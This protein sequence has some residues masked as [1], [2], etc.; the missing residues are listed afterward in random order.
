MPWDKKHKRYRNIFSKFT[1]YAPLTLPTIAGLIPKDLNIEIEACD[2]MIE[3]A[4]KYLKN[5]Y[6]IVMFSF[7]TPSS[8]RAYYLSQ[9]F[10]ERGAYTVFG[11]YHTTFIPE[12]AR[13][14]ADTIII[15]EGEISIPMFINDY[16]KGDPKDSYYNPN[17]MQEH[18]KTPDRSIL[19]KHKYSKVPT[20]IASKGCPNK[21]EFCAIN[22]MSNNV[23]RCIKDV[24][25]EMKSLK[26]KQYIFFDPNFFGNKEYAIKLMQQMKALK[27]NWIGCATLNTAFNDELM[28]LAKESGCLGLLVGI[29]SLNLKS[30]KSVNK[31]FVDPNRCKEAIER[32]QKRGI[33]VNGC[34]VLG[35]DSDTEEELMELP[36]KAEYLKLNLVRYSVL[37]PTPNSSLY[38]RLESEGR[39]M[40][41]D[42]SKY[43]QN[44]V[45]FTPKNISKEKLQ[46]IYKYCWEESFKIS[47]IYRRTK[48]M[49]E[50]NFYEKILLLAIN[51][52]FK[53]VGKDEY[54]S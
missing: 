33:S 22:K 43:T 17:I 7:I 3:D 50:M 42:W 10:R 52:G 46:E 8:S 24:I 13:N 48:G 27:I 38:K 12:E 4:E 28:D 20:I 11:G 14:F 45:V 47:S 34:F 6:D 2:E 16:L 31:G 15:G 51:I 32:I 23:P 5:T 41:S 36:R 37:T 40:T 39:I 19:K 49:N 29:E 54:K 53:F 25:D 9:Q 1:A 30:L 26:S 21:C 35:F 18:R 44:E